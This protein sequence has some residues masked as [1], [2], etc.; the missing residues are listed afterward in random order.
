M[1][2]NFPNLVKKKSH[3]FRKYGV[4]SKMNPKRPIPRYIIIKMAK[5]KDKETISYIIF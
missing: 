3:E 2:E 4:P 5:V 1:V